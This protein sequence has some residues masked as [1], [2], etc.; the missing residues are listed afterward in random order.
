[1]GACVGSAGHKRRLNS[2]WPSHVWPSHVWPSL[3]W[4]QD[5]WI[6]VRVTTWPF[7]LKRRH[8]EV[9]NNTAAVTLGRLSGVT[10]HSVFNIRAVS[11]ARKG[12]RIGANMM[13]IAV[14]LG[15]CW[16]QQR[17]LGRSVYGQ[18]LQ[19]P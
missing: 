17:G 16:S 12:G 9:T 8:G 10:T 13:G 7:C 19:V 3:V 5:M 11:Q 6:R 15:G 2:M 14:E 1:M 18:Q 4:A